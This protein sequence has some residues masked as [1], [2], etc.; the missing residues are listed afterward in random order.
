MHT[1]TWKFEARISVIPNASSLQLSPLIISLLGLNAGGE[2]IPE[3]ND[4]FSIGFELYVRLHAKS[5]LK[6]WWPKIIPLRVQRE[7]AFFQSISSQNSATPDLEIDRVKSL[8]LSLSGSSIF[9]F[10]LP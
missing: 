5:L 1:S 6:I 3:M 9:F 10:S 4:G 8:S 7:R 2:D